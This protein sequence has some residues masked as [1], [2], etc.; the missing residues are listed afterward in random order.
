MKR[1]HGGDWAEFQRENGFVPL[2]FSASISPL[3]LPSEVREAVLDSLDRADRYPD[4]HCTE[5][6]SALSA[7]FGIPAESIVCG[8][9]AAD[10]IYRLVLLLKPK[11]ALV[12]VPAFTEY[13]HALTLAGCRVK[14]IFCQEEE[15]FVLPEAVLDAISPETDLVFLCNPNNPTGQFVPARLLERIRQRCEEAGCLL[16]VDECFLGFSEEAE[17]RSLLGCLSESP[18]LVLLRAFTK[19][20]AMPGLRLGAALCGSVDLAER[21]RA[22]GQPWSVSAPAQ[23]AGFAALQ[24]ENYV[25]QVRVCVKE[26][27]AFLQRELSEIGLRVIHGEANFLLFFTVEQQLSQKLREKGILIRDCSDFT[28]LCP[29]WYRTAV[30]T[31][32]EN[33]LLLQALK[34]VL[35]GS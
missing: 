9:G 1:K 25:N 15:N 22:F 5:L 31:R 7:R 10:L 4:P 2:D 8:N 11:N 13:E 17:K 6:C 35:H 12:P 20:Y 26:E 16:V 21:L 32:Q 24:D 33:L 28:G 3:G 29:G 14:R 19:L 23:A 34:E 27:R 18:H 30:R